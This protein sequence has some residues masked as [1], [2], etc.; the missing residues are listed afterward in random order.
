MGLLMTAAATGYVIADVAAMAS[1]FNSPV[2]NRMIAEATSSQQHTSFSA[3]Q[4]A[5]YALVGVGMNGRGTWAPL[6][7]ASPFRRSVASS[8]S[9]WLDG[10]DEPCVRTRTTP[11]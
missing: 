11:I 1:R 2:L 7:R 8:P 6:T 3:G 10:S 4:V 9:L 5:A